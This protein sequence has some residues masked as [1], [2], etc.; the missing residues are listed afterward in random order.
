MTR[1]EHGKVERKRK[2]NPNLTILAPDDAFDNADQEDEW[3]SFIV[4]DEYNSGFE[5][6]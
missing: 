2:P 1:R 4:P 6:L 5:D 3:P